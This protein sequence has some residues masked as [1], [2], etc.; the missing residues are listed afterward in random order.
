MKRTTNLIIKK[1]GLS[2]HIEGGYFQETYRSNFPTVIKQGK[3]KKQRNAA[4]AI[5][6]LLTGKNFSAFHRL[7]CDE[8]WNYH[9]GTPV[10]L[11]V[12]NNM[13]K[14]LT[15]KLGPMLALGQHP[16]VLI[17]A[18]HWF[19]ATPENRRYYSLVT[20]LTIPGFNYEDFE[21]ARR[22]DLLKQ[23]PQYQDVILKFTRS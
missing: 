23:F 20:C 21:L 13:G 5:Y 8:I 7:T 6:F 10:L 9:L 3:I 14:L 2:R 12:I 11:Y 19:A 17:K 15:Y 22:K 16:Q 4:T 1:L 18:G